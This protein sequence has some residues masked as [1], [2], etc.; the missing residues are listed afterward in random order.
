MVTSLE[1][2]E[3][4]PFL[5]TLPLRG[6]LIIENPKGPELR[7]MTTSF[8]GLRVSVPSVQYRI[9]CISK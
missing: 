3:D 6:R 7:E 9:F 5:G 4:G 8:R 1:S 2:L